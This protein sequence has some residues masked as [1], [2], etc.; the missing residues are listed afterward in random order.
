MK[1]DTRF[2]CSCYKTFSNLSVILIW[3]KN[4]TC[5]LF[6]LIINILSSGV[7]I[8]V[9]T[10]HSCSEDGLEDATQLLLQ[11]SKSADPLRS[12]I[13]SLLVDGLC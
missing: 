8:E 2:N 1:N 9:L 3:M 5:Y 4:Q 13:V 11:L 12:V 10:S 7:C 6:K